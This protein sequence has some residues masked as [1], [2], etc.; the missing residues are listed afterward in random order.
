MQ[1]RALPVKEQG[2]HPK[3]FDRIML[4]EETGAWAGT[5]PGVGY[6]QFRVFSC[7]LLHSQSSQRCHCAEVPLFMTEMTNLVGVLVGGIGKTLLAGGREGGCCPRPPAQGIQ[8]SCMAGCGP[9]RSQVFLKLSYL[10]C[11]LINQ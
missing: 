1:F 9:L 5:E 3:D 8:G 11:I 2:Q 6:I 10:Y 4:G 7:F